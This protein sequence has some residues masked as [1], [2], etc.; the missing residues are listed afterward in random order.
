M[1][2]YAALVADKYPFGIS[3]FSSNKPSV[4]EVSTTPISPVLTWSYKNE[5][6]TITE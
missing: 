5:K 6:H 1:S 3:S 2:D 4:I